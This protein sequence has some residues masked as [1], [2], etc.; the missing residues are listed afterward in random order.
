MILLL[1]AALVADLYHVSPAGNDSK[2]GRSTAT[3]PLDG[4]NFVPLIALAPGVMLP[5]GQFLPRINGSR[6]RTS[7]Y[8]YDGVSV[9]EP[10]PGQVAYYPVL[11]SIA[12][13]RVQMDARLAER[14]TA[15][16][17]GFTALKADGFSVM[18]LIVSLMLSVIGL[19]GV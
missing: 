4:R 7:E 3:L 13:F 8:L 18:S 10:E 6:P 17:E 9:L 12:E 2:D 5:P 19:T 15:M 1:A 16:H 14:L 11:D